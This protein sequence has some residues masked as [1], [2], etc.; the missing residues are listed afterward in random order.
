MH[1]REFSGYRLPDHLVRPSKVEIDTAGTDLANLEV[2][3]QQALVS[4]SIGA[5]TWGLIL[6]KSK[7]YTTGA[8]LDNMLFVA[9]AQ[10]RLTDVA[11]LTIPQ[12]RRLLEMAEQLQQ[13]YKQQED[14]NNPLVLQ[15]VALNYHANPVAKDVFK[16]KLAAQTLK[17]L[18]LHVVG[19]RASDV[20]GDKKL[21]RGQITKQDWRDIHD[22]FLKV[23]NKLWAQPAIRVQFE[24]NL[25]IL[26]PLEQP[27]LP[28]INF[29]VPV[30]KCSS[31]EFAHDLRILH[32]KYL[33]I[34]KKIA[35]L[36]VN[37]EKLDE[38]G[39]PQLLP[40]DERVTAIEWFG[41]E[42]LV[43]ATDATSVETLIKWLLRVSKIL[44]SGEVMR[45]SNDEA[46]DKT[47][48]IRDPAY[49]MS[50]VKKLDSDIM[51]VNLA[52]RILSTGN[53]LA[54][55]G[56]HRVMR[57]SVTED[58]LLEKERNENE[59]TEFFNRGE[60]ELAAK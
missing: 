18:H 9:R 13:V 27:V 28:G 49:T 48:F 12:L 19:F 51:I 11:Q 43:A 8:G 21:E 50:L 22:P 16:K 59:I 37:V 33:I 30:E 24:Q 41:Q 25:Q 6:P 14:P 39:M 32:E 40:Y 34:Y 55:L 1:G 54:T 56:L 20:E 45:G 38:T 58:W 42:L 7:T 3:K 52:P 53:L 46:K 36:F 10:E 26:Q 35:G 57:G 23:T 17:D 5:E 47:I 44:V 15:T 31:P 29:S 60:K 2:L 4:E